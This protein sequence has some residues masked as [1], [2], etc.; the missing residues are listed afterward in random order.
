[1][2]PQNVQTIASPVAVSQSTSVVLQAL[3]AVMLGLFVVGFAGFSQ[4]DAVHNAA[5]D[6]RHSN[7][8]PCH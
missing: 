1:M 3:F 8:F 7:A 4:L 2:L 6:T 5:H